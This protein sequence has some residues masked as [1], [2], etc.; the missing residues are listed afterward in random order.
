[1]KRRLLVLLLVWVVASPAFAT[2]PHDLGE[3]LTYWRL[4]TLPADL[5]SA[6]Q[7]GACVLDLRYA[8][9]DEAAAI[10]LAGWLKLHAS[11]RTPVLILANPATAAPLLRTLAPAALP[12]GTLTLGRPG[13]GFT[14]DLA[15]A[16]TAETEQL[17]YDAFT[18]GTT[19]AALMEENL[20][21]ERHDEAAI[22]R[23]LAD[24]TPPPAA[25]PAPGTTPAGALPPPPLIDRTLQRAVQVHRGLLALQ[26]VRP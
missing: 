11:T 20:T 1:M 9:G 8:A 22:V 24:G 12:T 23:Q 26:V 15:I 13:A 5:P 6:G 16:T 18:A 3:G 7:P 14:P 17:A 25:E 4:A 10:A 2:T 19:P 21:K